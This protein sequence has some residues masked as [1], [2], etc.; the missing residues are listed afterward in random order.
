MTKLEHRRKLI[1][2]FVNAIYLYDDK[3]LLTFN[4]KDGT[5]TIVLT[6][7]GEIS[8]EGSDL[9]ASGAPKNRRAHTGAAMEKQVYEVPREI[10]DA[11]SRL[12]LDGAGFRI[13]A[14]TPEQEAYLSGWKV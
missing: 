13:D 12:K 9:S 7:S 8:G 11:V 10:D 5:K 6:D 3:I 2:I 1:D 4:Y 14:L